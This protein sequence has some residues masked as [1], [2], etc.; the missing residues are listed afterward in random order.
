MA[1]GVPVI[2]GDEDGSAEPLQDGLVGWR[3]PHR[4]A[5]KVAKA[6]LEILQGQD[7]RCHPQWLRQQT[8]TKFGTKTLQAKLRQL[9]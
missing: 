8:V 6:C 9:I 3:V 4:D 1:C 7:Q 2:S 5:E